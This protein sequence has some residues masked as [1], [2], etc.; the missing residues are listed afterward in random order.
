MN[1]VYSRA[2]SAGIG[3]LS[4]G[5][6]TRQYDPRDLTHPIECCLL[7]LKTPLDT[8]SRYNSITET[9]ELQADC[10]ILIS[11]FHIA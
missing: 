3:Q 7:R 11:Q 6:Y 2:K 4:L 5:L 9:A 8:F 1:R 10:I